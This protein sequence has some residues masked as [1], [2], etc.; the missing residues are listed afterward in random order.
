[1]PGSKVGTLL[2][3]YV[4]HTH[5]LDSRLVEDMLDDYKAVITEAYFIL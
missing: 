5:N 2:T 1:M 4:S 3:A